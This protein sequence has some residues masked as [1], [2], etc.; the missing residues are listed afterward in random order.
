MR[1]QL[2][3]S[4]LVHGG[5]IFKRQLNSTRG[6]KREPSTD[7]CWNVEAG[8]W[9]GK[10]QGEFENFFL[11]A[12]VIYFLRLITVIVGQR[13]EAISTDNILCIFQTYLAAH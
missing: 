9:V 13:L 10:W 1:K 5:H 3:L 6:P 11:F 4:F 2:V 8:K 12:D 7:G